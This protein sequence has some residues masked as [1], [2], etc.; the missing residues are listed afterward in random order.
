MMKKV[1]QELIDYF[2]NQEGWDKEEILGEYCAG[3]L[4]KYDCLGIND[5]PLAADEIDLNWGEELNLPLTLQ[6]FA[7]E[8]FDEIMQG[9]CNV[10]ATA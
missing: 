1:C 5:Q 7:N 9:V 8:L 3:I 2:E 4:K 6:D 10:I